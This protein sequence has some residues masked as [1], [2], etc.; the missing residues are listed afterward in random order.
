MESTVTRLRKRLSRT[1]EQVLAS[2]A[3]D[4]SMDCYVSTTIGVPQVMVGALR[5]LVT[6][7]R[8]SEC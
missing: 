3:R 1:D 4:G 5:R 8:R 2:S 6:A 7:G